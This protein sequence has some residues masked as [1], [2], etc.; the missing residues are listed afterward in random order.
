MKQ[1]ISEKDVL[2]SIIEYLNIKRILY[3]R[4]QTGALVVEN[5]FVKFGSKGSP[6]I[7]V[8]LKGGKCIGIEVKSP[9]GTQ[10]DEQKKWEQIFESC[11]F[12]YIL[13]RSLDDVISRI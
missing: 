11:G 13:A 9:T 5:R 3:I 6:D 2:K 10:S 7:F 1:K 8:F 4:N 12:R